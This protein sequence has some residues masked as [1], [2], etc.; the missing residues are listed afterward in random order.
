MA[1]RRRNAVGFAIA[2][3]VS[4]AQKMH[5]GGKLEQILLVIGGS[6]RSLARLRPRGGLCATSQAAALAIGR[7]AAAET[8]RRSRCRR[9]SH[10]VGVGQDRPRADSH[11]AQA[12]DERVDQDLAAVDCGVRHVSE[13]YAR[14]LLNCKAT[15]HW[16]VGLSGSY[17]GGN[18]VVP[19]PKLSRSAQKLCKPMPA[20]LRRLFHA[21]ASRVLPCY[22]EKMCRM[23]RTGRMPRL[24]R[25]RPAD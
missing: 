23:S 19:L 1:V 2:G 8:L 5:S 9:V 15:V 22:R 25:P 18:D 16:V 21:F 13:S 24:S 14:D 11:R 7:P 17:P 20:S 10:L 4:R 3:L 12:Q 6:R